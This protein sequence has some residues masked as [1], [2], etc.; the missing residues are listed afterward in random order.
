MDTRQIAVILRNTTNFLGVFP[1]DKL[2]KAKTPFTL[3]ANTD[4]SDRPG[5]HWVA[6]HVAN[7]KAEYFDSYGMGP[8]IPTIRRFLKQF[9]KCQYSKKQ[10]QGFLS[11]VCGH[12]SV[13]YLWYRSQE[14]SMKDILGRFSDNL[15]E[16]DELITQWLNDNFKMDTDTYDV[17]FIVNQICSAMNKNL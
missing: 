7:G 8:S 12:Y 11:S 13:Y 1:S 9:K 16:N 10:I 17:H 4:P 3:V 15:E 2:P 14:I 6:I 5:T